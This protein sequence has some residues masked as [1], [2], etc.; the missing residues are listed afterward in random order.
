[1]RK[2]YWRPGN[3]LLAVH[4]FFRLRPHIECERGYFASWWLWF[5]VSYAEPRK[6]REGEG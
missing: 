3:W 4:P 6:E 2:R 5:E 1:M